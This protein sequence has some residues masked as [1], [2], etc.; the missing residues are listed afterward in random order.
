MKADAS[1]GRHSVSLKKYNRTMKIALIGPGLMPIPPK[2]WGGVENFM[3]SYYLILTGLGHEVEIFNTTDL[4]HVAKR[5]N[6]GGYD[7]VHLHYDLYSRFFTKHLKA[8]FCTTSHYG[9]I[10]KPKKWSFGYHAINIDNFNAPGIIALSDKINESYIDNGYRGWIS[11]LKVGVKVADFKFNKGKGNGRA[12]FLGKIEPRKRQAFLAESLRGKVNI[13]FAGPIVDGN[14]KENETCRYVG[15]WDRP[16]LYEHLT[17]YNCLVLLSDG[18]AAPAVVPEALAAGLSIVVSET[19]SA[20]LGNEK[21][22]TILPDDISDAKA[23]AAA[24]NDQIKSNDL[25]RSE[26]REYAEDKFDNNVIVGEYLDMA[27]KFKNHHLEKSG[28]GFPVPG[29]M[30]IYWLSRFYLFC[31]HNKTCRYIFDVVRG[32]RKINGKK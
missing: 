7:F 23:I 10:L 8:P 25:I 26:I 5:I 17:D 16:Y 28:N 2:N 15:V 19:A 30:P 24:I 13:D 27:S 12:L 22:V 18:E 31:S 6:E 14:F 29:Q 21:F 1:A 20:N 11:V 3:W 4:D 32:R 9:Y